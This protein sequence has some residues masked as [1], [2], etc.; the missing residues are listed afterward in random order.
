MSIH[1]AS[2]RRSVASLAAAFPEA[3]RR[4]YLPTYRW[5]LELPEALRSEVAK[6][7]GSGAVDDL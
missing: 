3:R 7:I 5:V 4:I 1:V 2:R 6:E